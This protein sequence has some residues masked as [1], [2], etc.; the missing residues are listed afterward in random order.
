MRPP[1]LRWKV[2]L[3]LLAV[4]VVAVTLGSVLRSSGNPRTVVTIRLTP[5][6]LAH[7][8]SIPRI[9]FPHAA[10]SEAIFLPAPETP[11]DRLRAWLDRT[12]EK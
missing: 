5:A 8:S 2:S 11:L 12:F 7:S 6:R 3:A 1:I 9:V 10:K 4:V